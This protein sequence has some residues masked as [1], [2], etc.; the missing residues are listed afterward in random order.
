[1]DEGIIAFVLVVVF[2]CWLIYAIAA[3]L[4]EGIYY[5]GNILNTCPAGECPTDRVTGEKKCPPDSTTR[6]AYDPNVQTCQPV[7]YCGSGYY[8][9]VQNDGSTDPRGYCPYGQDGNRQPCRC[10]NNPY[11]ANYIKSYFT[12]T[13]G[14]AYTDPNTTFV[15][16]QDPSYTTGTTTMNSESSGI[17]IN[18]TTTDFCTIP[19]DWI[20]KS[21]PGCSYDPNIDPNLDPKS[22][23]TNYKN[24]IACMQE[25][26]CNVGILAFIADNASSFVESNVNYY[27]VGCVP[28]T[29]CP[30]DGSIP[31]YDKSYGKVI[32]RQAIPDLVE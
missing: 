12:V 28:G 11:C 22:T 1:M 20:Y 3:S 5:S 13:G 2:W 15:Q 10:L 23:G 4:S 32:C 17:R 21:T 14:N 19:I 16:V 24:A 30:D 8:Y 25:N 18:N 6:Y 27:P 29:I 7:G 31:I 9:A 26:P